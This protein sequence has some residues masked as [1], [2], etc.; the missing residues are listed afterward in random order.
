MEAP[1]TTSDGI[2][3]FPDGHTYLEGK[4]TQILWVTDGFGWQEISDNRLI[5]IHKD[6]TLGLCLAEGQTPISLDEAEWLVLNHSF[7]IVL[8]D[9]LM[10]ARLPFRR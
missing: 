6:G 9:T 7:A 2:T 1:T 4:A 3:S 5:A 8:G 10:T